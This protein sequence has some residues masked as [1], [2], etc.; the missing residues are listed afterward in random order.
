MSSQYHPNNLDI[1]DDAIETP[2]PA[3]KSRELLATIDDLPQLSLLAKIADISALPNT[4]ATSILSGKSSPSLSSSISL[5]PLTP[6]LSFSTTEKE[7]W[8]LV[9]DGLISIIKMK[10]S[11]TNQQSLVI[12]EIMSLLSS[13]A[14]N[15]EARK[16]FH[17]SSFYHKIFTIMI[18]SLLWTPLPPRTNPFGDQWATDDDDPYEDALWSTIRAP[19]WS[20][21]L[22][23]LESPDL[24][25]SE[26]KEEISKKSFIPS[27]FVRFDSEDPREREAA[28]TILHR[29]Y[30]KFL[31][32]RSLIR[33]KIREIFKE[34]IYEER[35]IFLTNGFDFK[36]HCGGIGAEHNS[37]PR[38][39]IAENEI[40]K[41][42][43]Q[44]K[45]LPHLSSFHN[46]SE[47][48]EIL[49]SI[50]NGFAIPLRTEHLEFLYSYLIPLLKSKHLPSF[51]SQLSLCIM[52]YAE[53]D[54]ALVSCR[55]IM[56]IIAIFPKI[57][58]VKKCIFLLLMEELL[59]IWE[60]NYIANNDALDSEPAMIEEEIP[61]FI[62]ELFRLLSREIK[63]L[64]FQV[65]ERALHYFCNTSLIGILARYYPTIMREVMT[66][67]DGHNSL[68]GG[69]HW[70]RLVQVQI[71]NTHLLLRAFDPIMYDEL[72]VNYDNR[73]S[74]K[75]INKNLQKYLINGDTSPNIM[76]TSRGNGN[77]I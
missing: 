49:A 76:D 69:K 20:L 51:H 22:M 14:S 71:D 9:M 24:L 8:P 43:I 52:Q 40:Q 47:I 25:P 48:L 32:L 39:C 54:P 18:P 29:I 21:F 11:S 70:N 72:C 35:N 28:K 1:L 30:G 44:P 42:I 10:N 6:S 31:P 36:D 65:A 34:F 74:S 59:E 27:L 56:A 38:I 33:G 53:K 41:I 75:S 64:H 77:G 68:K 3:S 17:S 60:K 19:A 2:S 13:S 23:I 67:E 58:S 5:S 46:I 4:S 37:R 15:V 57:S 73:V 7:D 16:L 55:L 63:S 26:A 62:K 66:F 45:L 50:I 61:A 12:F